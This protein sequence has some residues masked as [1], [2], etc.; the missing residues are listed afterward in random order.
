MRNSA[1]TKPRPGVLVVRGGAGLDDH[2]RPSRRFAELGYVV[3]AANMYGRGVPGDRQR[4][5]ERM[6]G[7]ASYFPRIR[8]FRRVGTRVIVTVDRYA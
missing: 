8:E 3:L 4:I 2:A 7:S 1:I 5:M 6:A